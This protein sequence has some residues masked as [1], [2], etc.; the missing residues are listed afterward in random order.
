MATL[1]PEDFSDRTVFA[2]RIV[3]IY[4]E[5]DAKRIF[6]ALATSGGLVCYWP[7]PLRQGGQELKLPGRPLHDGLTLRWCDDRSLITQSEAAAKGQIYVQSASSFYAV[8]MLDLRENMEVLDLSAAPGG[9]TIAMAARMNNTGRIAAVEPIARRFHRLR[10]NVERCGVTNVD[11]YQRD[12]RGVG[13]AVPGRFERVLLDT[14]CSSEAR[15]R[16]DNP[17]TY[18]HWRLKKLKETQRKQKALIMSAF[19]ALKPGG[20]LVYCTCSFAPEENELVMAHL[21]RRTDAEID[22]LT[23][24]VEGIPLRSGLTRW[25]RRQMPDALA[26]TL[27]IFPDTPW[28][29]FY[30]A[31]VRK[32]A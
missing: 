18:R 22:P 25:R 31:R 4:G 28:D 6:K 11:F 9:K 3:E 32:P 30:I 24:K 29:G 2:D 19:Q 5:S 20:V 13:R 12:G 8:E 14:P 10:A 21:L 26:G 15:I 16:W 17:L 7:N 1:I 27:R 23:T